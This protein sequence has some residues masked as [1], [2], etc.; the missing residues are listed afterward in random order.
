MITQHHLIFLR[1]LSLL[2]YAFFRILLVILHIALIHFLMLWL[3]NL[4]FITCLHLCMVLQYFMRLFGLWVPWP[5]GSFEFF[6]YLLDFTNVIPPVFFCCLPWNC[7]S[8][9]CAACAAW[10][11]SWVNLSVF[12]SVEL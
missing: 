1:L 12:V 10:I 3:K 4:G 7:I 2:P 11:T 6:C 8:S 9:I 5:D